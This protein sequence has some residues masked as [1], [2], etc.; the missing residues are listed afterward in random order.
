MSQVQGSAD[1]RPEA[2]LEGIVEALATRGLTIVDDFLPPLL[3]ADLAREA[4]ELWSE[5]GFRGAG[6]GQG[7]N[8]Q[9]NA[10]IRTDRILWLNP[11]TASPAQCQYLASLE[12]LRLAIN[13]A[14][15]LGLFEFEGHLAI[16]P[17]G[18]YYRKHLDQF[19]D[20]DQRL[21]STILYLNPGWREEDG[22]QLRIYTDPTDASRQEQVL[23]L[24][25]RL[26]CFLSD[27]FV[28]E[29][30]PARRERMSLTGWFRKRDRLP[31]ER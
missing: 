3:V 19:R 2:L 17:A 16:Y 30:L 27:R 23:P 4:R 10:A 9:Q 12:A 21:V 5:G 7:A 28:H 6:I 1:R 15:F 31:G 8:L 25:G 26:V 22:G 18:A 20:Q 13:R 24:A 29:V 11:A 14:L